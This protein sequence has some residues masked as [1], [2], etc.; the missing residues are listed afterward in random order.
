MAVSSRVLFLSFLSVLVSAVVGHGD[1]KFQNVTYDGRS[2]IIN[3]K[4]ELLFSGS[5]HYTRSTPE[6]WPDLISKAKHGGLNVIQTYVFWNIHEPVEGQYNFNGNYDLVKFIKLIGEQGMYV[7]LRVGPFI[8]AEWNHGGLPYWLREI[9][10]IIFRSD[11]DPFK[12]HMKKYVKMIIDKMK[13]EKLFA[14]Q[15]G[16]IILTQIENEYNHIQLA[17][18]DL[19][20]RY[21]QWAANMA[22][23]LKTEVPWIMCKQKDAPDPVINTCN[24][25]HCGDTFT[26]P[27]KPYKPSLWTENWTAQYRVFGDPP[28]QRAAEDIAFSVARFFS[29]NGTLVNY[30]MYH[31]G[32]NFGRTSAVFTTTRYYDEAP[33]DEYGLQREPKW[34][35]LKD[36]H[37]ALNLCKKALLWGEPH[38]ES[39]GKHTEA[40][41]YENSG[42][43]ICAAFLANNNSRAAANVHFRGETYYLPPRS[44]SILPDCKTVVY[45][46][47]TIVSQHNA[48]NLKKSKVA[49]N[50]KWDMS[51]EPIPSVEQL[52]VDSRTPK[53][54]YGFLKDTTDYAWYTTSIELAPRDLPMRPDILPVLR[55]ASLGHALHAF[56]N[57][58]YVGSAHG[59]HDEKSF[60]FQSAVN[61]KSGVNHIALIGMTVGLPDSGAYMEHR[62]AGPRSVT[63]LGLNTG[64]LDLSINGWGHQVGLTGEKLK[65]FTQSGSHRVGWK[66]ANGQGPALTWYK[67]YFE[68]PE[69]N[70]PVA[71][72][73]NGMGK[74]MVWVNG[75]SIGRYWVSFLSPLGKPSQSEYHIPRSFIK[76]T[77][78]LLII[79]EEEK[80][81]PE[82]IELVLVNRD[83]ICS[84]VT[85]YH[86][87]HVKSWQR[88]DSKIRPVVDI[89]KPAAQ[90]H[91]PNHKKIV[92]VEFASFGDPYGSCGSFFTGKCS[93]SITKEVVEQHCLGKTSCSVPIER[94]L[95]IKDNDACPDIKKTLAI[96]VKC[97]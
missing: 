48:R 90:L 11:N 87:P 88:K 79:L 94:E 23:G 29:K 59:S 30:Y 53:E 22:V 17:Y 47:Q 80:G 89:V 43:R 28:S 84:F 91:C 8:Q 26:G 75:K 5:I 68:A 51:P 78:N 67:T 25:R 18:R 55:V 33:I 39:L 77:E 27:N 83:T 4:R 16:P 74:G 57:G 24:G 69:G 42:L 37:K 9:P 92:A 72:R 2:L 36:L 96:Q 7:T 14:S 86:P 63:V 35:H 97:E 34:S 62:F 65:V 46:T 70:N 38:V 45:N 21:V 19:G 71:I 32:T 1:K 15:G 49:K 12:K 82:D 64:T 95:F 61:F 85:E 40:Q 20:S 31:G 52:P 41:V 66:N 13:E 56:V 60:V 73:M 81:N 44:I 58:E 50:L 10:N 93:A 54:L 3:G 6:M 76:P